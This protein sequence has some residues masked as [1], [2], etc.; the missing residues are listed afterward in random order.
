MSDMFFLEEAADDVGLFL[1][2]A[3]VGLAVVDHLALAGRV[4]AIEGVRFDLMVQ[5]F[6]GVQ[7]GGAGGQ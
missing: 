5:Q 7:S 2:S 1:G 6:V 4:A 3:K